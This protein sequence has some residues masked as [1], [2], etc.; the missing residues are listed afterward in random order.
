MKLLR[1]GD[2]GN[3]IPAIIDKNNNFRDLSSVVKDFT[4]NT[5]NFKTI[6]K[7]FMNNKIDILLDLAQKD[8]CWRLYRKNIDIKFLRKCLNERY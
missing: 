1:V 5:L 2:K 4:P 8:P 7:I 6:D 3:E